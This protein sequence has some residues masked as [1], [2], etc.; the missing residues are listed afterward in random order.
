M[1]RL[2]GMSGILNGTFP[3]KGLFHRKD[4]IFLLSSSK[5]REHILVRLGCNP[6]AMDVAVYCA[7]HP[8][9]DV[10]KP[11]N[12]QRRIHA[13]R[14]EAVNVAW[15]TFELPTG[16]NM[17][18]HRTLRLSL[19]NLTRSLRQYGAI[20]EYHFELSIELSY[21][22]T[23]RHSSRKVPVAQSGGHEENKRGQDFEDD[24]I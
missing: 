8:R 19:H 20:R 23:S 5:E 6:E 7:H 24:G 14:V 16:S 15:T 3:R 4:D 11:V 17:A 10:W 12:G 22:R 21:E 1:P 9:L 18:R 13:L 2:E